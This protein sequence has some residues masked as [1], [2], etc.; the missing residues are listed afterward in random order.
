[1][2]HQFH[3]VIY[4]SAI[5]IFNTSFLFNQKRLVFKWFLMLDSY[6]KYEYISHKT[7]YINMFFYLI[8]F[9]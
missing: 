2:F 4:K 5:S 9:Y 3:S 6:N 8:P 7:A 1:M